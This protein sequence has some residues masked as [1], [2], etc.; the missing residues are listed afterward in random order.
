MEIMH[1]IAKR[2]MS[3]GDIGMT[4]TEQF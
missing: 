2:Q 1:M 4:T 3:D